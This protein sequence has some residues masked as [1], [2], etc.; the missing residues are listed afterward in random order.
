MTTGLGLH[1]G[2][3]WTKRRL[4]DEAKH[5]ESLLDGV[6]FLKCGE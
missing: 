3:T 4:G 5:R 1:A 6:A 2:H